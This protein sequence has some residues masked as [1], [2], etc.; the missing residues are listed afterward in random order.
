MI[1]L[2]LFLCFIFFGITG[3]TGQTAPNKYWVQFTDKNNSAFSVDQPEEFLSAKTIERRSAFNIPIEEN[4]L[5]VNENYIESVLELGNIGLVNTSRW[6]NAITIYTPDS[7]LIEAIENLGVVQGVRSVQLL[8]GQAKVP[9]EFIKSTFSSTEEYGESW[10]Q[11]EMIGIHLLHELGFSGN[12][13]DV[14]I[15][16]AG[17]NKVD[18]MDVFTRAYDEERIIE[19]RDFVLGAEDVYGYSNHGS[20][21]LSILAGYQKDSLIGSGYGANL[22]LFRTEEGAQE[23]VVEEDNWVSAAEYCDQIGIDLINTSL[24]YSTFDDSTANHTYEDMD[25]NSTRITVASDIAA[26]KGMLLVTS[27]GNS[28]NSEWRYITAPADADSCLTVGAVD[29]QRKHAPFSSFGPTFDGRVKPDVVAVGRSCAY[30]RTDNTISRGNGTSFSSPLLAGAIASLWEAHPGKS[31][32][33]IIDA[34]K[35]SAHLYSTPNDSLGY[36]IPNFWLA[37]LDL[38]NDFHFVN[39]D[40]MWSVYPNPFTT[41]LHI[42]FEA[43]KKAEIVIR[44]YNMQ[45][46]LLFED[47]FTH[48]KDDVFVRTLN[49][50]ILSLSI[51]TYILSLEIDGDVKSTLV[52][53]I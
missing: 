46:E 27:A 9:Q 37:H 14:A 15:L 51:G 32:M 30:A 44:L 36:G 52:E 6:F 19:T 26:S 2:H 49:Q 21:V 41:D 8:P 23:N 34:V 33:E 40:I 18:E 25:G 1:R 29:L 24:G 42:Q 48:Q 38:S 31:N 11:S 45:G 3:V 13:I 16:D 20:Y 53:K 10:E 7:T 43:F 28:G 12:G 4:D 22:H 39:E 5:P 47:G 17:F 50:E 35:R